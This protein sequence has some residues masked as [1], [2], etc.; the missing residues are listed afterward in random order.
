MIQ[1]VSSLVLAL[2]FLAGSAQAQLVSVRQEIFGM[3]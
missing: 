2:A 3:D 1:T